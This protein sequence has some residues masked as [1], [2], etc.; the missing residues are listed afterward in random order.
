M[1]GRTERYAELA[2]DILTTNLDRLKAGKELLN[3]V[4]VKRGY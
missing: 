2:L 3:V 1:S 4:D